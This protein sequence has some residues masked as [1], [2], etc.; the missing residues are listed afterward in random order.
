MWIKLCKSDGLNCSEGE[1]GINVELPR[2]INCCRIDEG[3]C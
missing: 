1:N 3:C 2:R